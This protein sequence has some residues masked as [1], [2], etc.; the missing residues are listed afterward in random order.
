MNE[1][2]KIKEKYINLRERIFNDKDLIK[3]AFSF[4][5]NYS[6][7]VEEI[8][9]EVLEAEKIEYVLAS[10]GSFSRRELAPHSDIDLMFIVPEMNKKYGKSISKCIT[11]LWDC[12]IEASHTVREFSDIKRFLE[13]DLHALTQFFETRF[14]LGDSKIYADWNELLFSC[15]D[16]DLRVRLIYEYFADINV[17]HKKYGDSPKV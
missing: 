7:L 13:D 3:D 15:L 10:A 6:L 5:V 9:V 12:G 11:I 17:R 2:N 4:S 16:E 8:I 1:I 14:I